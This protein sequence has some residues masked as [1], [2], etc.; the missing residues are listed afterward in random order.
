M[1]NTPQFRSQQI[2]T[3]DFV[4]VILE[5]DGIPATEIVRYDNF[6]NWLIKPDTKRMMALHWALGI[7]GEVGELIEAVYTTDLEKREQNKI[8]ELGDLEFYFQALRNHYAISLTHLH[9]VELPPEWVVYSLQDALT[10]SQGLICDCIKR[11]YVY[12]KPRDNQAV[13][14]ALGFL[15]WTLNTLY[16]THPFNRAHILQANADKLAKRYVSLR[17]SDAAAIDR[18]DKKAGPG[19]T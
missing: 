1:T 16:Y 8:E 12:G 17:Y 10:V 6:V 18:A 4:Y 7:A 9:G 2:D 11:E 15:A 13:E 19:E 3:D 5:K 14:Q